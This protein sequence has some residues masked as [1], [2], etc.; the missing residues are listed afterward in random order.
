MIADLWNV[1]NVISLIRLALIPWFIWLVATAEYGWAGVL[2]GVIGSTD[3]LDGYLARRLGQVTEVGKLL[4][5]L[6]DR[7]AVAVAVIAGLI[8]GVLPIW[9]A[10]ALIVRETLIGIG[11][12]YGWT[13]GVSKLDVRYLGKAATLL[14]YIAMTLF[15]VGVGF[16]VSWSVAAAWLTGV[17]GLVM[18]YWV[19]AQYFTDMRKAIAQAG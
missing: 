2:L 1:P 13:K 7:L 12:L 6:A 3:W 9:F 18:Y 10:V 5:P 15:Y 19:A 16:D 8:T 14:L 4:D 11:A 17:P